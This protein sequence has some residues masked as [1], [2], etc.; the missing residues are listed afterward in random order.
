M[1]ELLNIL[2][3]KLRETYIF[4]IRCATVLDFRFVVTERDNNILIYGFHKELLRQKE[5]VYMQVQLC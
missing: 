4:I 1:S 3:N 2:R 5:D